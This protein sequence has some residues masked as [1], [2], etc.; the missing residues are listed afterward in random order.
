MNFYSKQVNKVL[1]ELNTSA[2]KGLSQSEARLRLDKYGLNTIEEKEKISSVKIFLS[3]FKN[4]IIWILIIAA[5]ISAVLPILE[6]GVENIVLEDMADALVI[7]VIVILNGVLGFIQEFKAEKSIEALKKLAGLK[8]TVIRDNKEDKIDA[9]ELVPGDII[10]LRT[11]DKIAADARLVELSNLETQEAALTGES[12]PV[13]KNLEVK[14]KDKVQIAEQTNT[15]F[16]GTIIT[17]GKGK[18]IVTATGMN[19]EIGK[20]AEMIQTTK[21]E[22]APLQRKLEQ[23]GKWLGAATLVIC[24]II[25]FTGWLSGKELFE[26]FLVAVSLAVAAIPEGLPA[27]VTIC[28]ALG[29]QRMVKKHA[30]IRKLPS[31][32]TL[33]STTVICSDKTG[34]L[35]RNEMTVRKVFVNNKTIEV[36][37]LGY[38]PDGNFAEMNYEL[39]QML[40]IGALCNDA[41]IEDNYSIIGDPTEAC[42]ITSAKKAGIEHDE[43]N[44]RFP[45]IDEIPFDSERKRMSTIHM[46]NGDKFV[47]TKGAP[48]QL[49]KVCSKILI[50][51]EERGLLPADKKKI[52]DQNEEFAKQ[53]LRLLG[54]AYAKTEKKEEK[55]MVFVGLQAM[56]DPPRKSSIEAV[57]KCHEAG[58]KVVMITGDHK[59]TAIAIAKEIGIEGDA[60]SG[61]E[62]DEIKDLSEIVDKISIFARVNPEHKMK[63]IE[64]LNKKG[65]VVAMT[66]D[67]VNDAPALKASHIGICVG[68]G[69]D[70]AKEASE[71]ILTNDDFASIVS[72]I[73][74]GRGIYDNIKK[75]VKFLISSNLGEIFTIFVGIILGFPLPVIAIQLLWINLMT[76]GLPALALGVEPIDHDIMQRKPRSIKESIIDK[77][78]TYWTLSIAVIMMVGTLIIFRGFEGLR[79]AQT[80]AFTTLMMFQM[81]NVLNCKSNIHSVFKIFFNN[82]W[83]ILAVALSIILQMI[84]LYVPFMNTLFKTYPLPIFE[85]MMILLVSSSVLWFDEIFKI[86]KRFNSTERA[87]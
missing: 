26:M 36:S 53:S 44:K 71:M 18:A 64:A 76:D 55:D 54:F 42:L 31:V 9:T 78:T 11:G 61:E 7:L 69:T 63:I 12:T 73:E 25:F 8:A 28:L 87:G 14:I 15:V 49:L 79:H 20:I 10:I 4:L 80:V 32:E 17:K 82:K 3:Q 51:G 5:V 30:L 75:F 74:E 16:S 70:V 68:S 58:I 38:K 22:Q 56:I 1:Q 40:M 29:V 60:L 66:G 37:G 45:R 19:T 84:V 41:V 83:L 86:V 21:K 39:K 6:R 72:A 43:L 33:G 27:V 48:D 59:I 52:S 35:T 47:Y 77:R 85:W 81:F 13:E 23:L 24:V 34:T 62:L 57:K 46:I 67:G 50:N 65:E 2:E